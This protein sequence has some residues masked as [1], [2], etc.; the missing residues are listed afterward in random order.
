MCEKIS[1]DTSIGINDEQ[2]GKRLPS[3]HNL[4]LHDIMKIKE[5]VN[6][7]FKSHAN[8]L[9]GVED[10]MTKY[11]ERNEFEDFKRNIDSKFD[12]I[13]NEIKGNQKDFKNEM[14]DTK[15]DINKNI[16]NLK[17]ELKSSIN[18]LP[19]NSDV[20]LALYK[21]NE[22]L[23]KE[24]KQNRNTII[25]WIIGFVGLGFTIAKSFGWL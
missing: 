3:L 10:N 24:T 9:N 2:K 14:R 23:T 25:G 20:E 8:E 21:N 13:L 18:S 12:N 22:K 17:T 4:S 19:T 1:E 7:Q 6:E 5:V 11:I 16:T 15:K